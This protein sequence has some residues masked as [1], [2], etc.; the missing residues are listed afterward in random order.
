[1]KSVIGI[2]PGL[3]G[4][5]AIV[6]SDGSCDVFDLPTLETIKKGKTKRGNVK[7]RRELDIEA[8]VLILMKLVQNEE[9][10]LIMF[11]AVHSM[12][13][14]GIA[15]AFTF[16]QTVGRLEGVIRSIGHVRI[17]YTTPQA[18]KKYHGILKQGKD[19]SV[20]LSRLHYPDMAKT[21]L[22][23]KDGR[24]DAVLIAEYGKF[25]SD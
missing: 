7:K 13:G 25:F 4:A 22:K 14:Q 20:R 21:F 15:G 8:F 5:I 17:Q 24:A 16:G 9:A 18:W 10:G 12:P 2:D 3:D 1:M 23:S 6:R 11:E 19:G